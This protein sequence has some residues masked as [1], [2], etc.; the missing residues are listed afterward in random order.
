MDV[1][2]SSKGV[3]RRRGAGRD[4]HETSM[5]DR[6]MELVDEERKKDPGGRLGTIGVRVLER[7]EAERDGASE[8]PPLCP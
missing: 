7:L 6:F 3:H 2:A 4:E 5:P 8:P 1:H